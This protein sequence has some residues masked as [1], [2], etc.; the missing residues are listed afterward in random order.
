LVGTERAEISAER[1]DGRFLIE[2]AL[3]GL[4]CMQDT[5]FA[6]DDDHA[7]I[8]AVESRTKRLNEI[9]FCVGVGA[10]GAS[11]DAARIFVDPICDDGRK[12]PL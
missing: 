9:G 7:D 12:N 1:D 10:F 3:G 6:A 11:P 4:V 5:R 2:H 8:Y